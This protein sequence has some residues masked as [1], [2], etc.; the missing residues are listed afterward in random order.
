MDVQLFICACASFNYFLLAIST[1]IENH[2]NLDE[3]SNQEN[4]R[5][6]EIKNRSSEK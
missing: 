1:F 2:L 5:F 3:N 6:N 4:N